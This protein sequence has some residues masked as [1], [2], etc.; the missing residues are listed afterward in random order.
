[1]AP[2]VLV[3]DKLAESAVDVFRNN[4]I[5][6]SFEPELGKDKPALLE[7]IGDY[8]G[9]AIRSST[10][11]TE[12]LLKRA[13]RLKV[14]GRAGV[15]VDN[16]DVSA[17]SKNG[18]VVMNTPFGNSITTAEHTIAMMMAVARQIPDA[19]RS[20][21]GGNWEKSR[22]MGVELFGKT[23]GV[24][25]CG[26]I[27]SAVCSRAIGLGMKVVGYDPYLSAEKARALGVDKIALHELLRR[28]DFI[29][30]HLPLIDKTRN[31]LDATSLSITKKGVR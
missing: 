22:F 23:L 28:S 11:V 8:D 7:A 26:N 2:K 4:G 14:V 24:I 12:K 15:G 13:G 20:V 19:N 30:L 16:V 25:G 18:I 29:T 3:S 17:A 1:M 9:L 31:K 6:V 21:H 10:K 5:D 27:G